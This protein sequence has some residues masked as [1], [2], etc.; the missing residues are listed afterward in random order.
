MNTIYAVLLCSVNVMPEGIYTSCQPMDWLF[1]KTK[2][3]CL[4]AAQDYMAKVKA[5]YGTEYNFQH[6]PDAAMQTR[7]VEKHP[8]WQEV[9]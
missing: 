6:S 3:E 5:G 9:R 7:C 8:D 2:E 4:A 1:P